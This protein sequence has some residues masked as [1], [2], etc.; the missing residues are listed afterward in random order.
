MKYCCHIWG[1]PAQTSLSFLYHMIYIMILYN[2]RQ[3][4]QAT[5]FLLPCLVCQ[6]LDKRRLFGITALVHR[7]YFSPFTGIVGRLDR[8]HSR[9]KSSRSS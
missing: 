8:T 2:W 9:P 4:Q 1:K 3:F 6:L 7:R 5:I